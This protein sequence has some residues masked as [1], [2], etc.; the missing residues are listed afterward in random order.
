MSHVTHHWSP[1]AGARPAPAEPA[2]TPPPDDVL[3]QT[4]VSDHS[5]TRPAVGPPVVFPGYEILAE[6][7]RG[8][9]G[10]VYK[11]RQ[12]NLNRLVA[13]KVI[14]GGPLASDEDKAR[15]RIEAEAAARLHHPNIVQVYDVGE[16]AGFSFMAL[17]L[18]EGET[19]RQ[20]QHERPTEARHAARLVAAVARAIQ[21]AHEQ[22][23]VHRDLKPANILLAPAVPDPAGTGVPLNPSAPTVRVRA[24]S[25]GSGAVVAPFVWVPKV[26]DFGLAKALAGGGA[27]LTGTGVAC[28]TPNYM[29]PE[30]VRGRPPAPG[31][32]VY[33]LGGLLFELLTGRAPFVGANP[34]DVM[35]QIVRADAPSVRKL[36]PKAPHDLAV[37]VSKC[38]EK[39]PARR[40]ATARDLADDLDRFVSGKPIAARPVG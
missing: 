33:G 16:H 19:L 9:M 11:A 4:V 30:Q 17:E 36:V 39:D 31:V 22:G 15:F 38:L 34:T 29:A 14:L 8:G 23:I 21:H 18:I 13:L 12:Q 3:Q 28:G 25:T 37:I 6:L 26:T 32:D 35:N 24:S 40:Y 10:V 7:G 2:V 1:F 5:R 20:W 27:D